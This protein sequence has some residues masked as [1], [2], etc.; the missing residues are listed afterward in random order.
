MWGAP[1]GLGAYRTRT[2]LILE[3]VLVVDL[4][5]PL[6]PA[7]LARGLLRPPL[8]EEP[9]AGLLRLL[10]EAAMA[11]QHGGDQGP[12][13]AP[14]HVHLGTHPGERSARRLTLQHP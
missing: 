13:A 3:V 1:V 2:L 8:V 14:H 5:D 11:A 7:R 9:D 4:A 10:L 12:G 6:R